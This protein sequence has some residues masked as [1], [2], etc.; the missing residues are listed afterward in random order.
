MRFLAFSAPYL[1]SS[2]QRRARV[3]MAGSVVVPDF[4]MMLMEKSLPSSS[5]HSSCHAR[6]DR[7]LPAKKT[8]GSESFR[9]WFWPLT[10]SMAARG[11]RYEPP[12]PTTTNTSE[13]ARMRSAARRMRCSSSVSSN[14][15]SSSQPR[16]SLP[17][18]RP[19]ASVLCAAKTS[20]SVASRSGRD[21][22]PQT[23]E[24]STFNMDTMLLCSVSPPYVIAKRPKTQVTSEKNCRSSRK[25]C[26]GSV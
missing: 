6:V 2:I 14:V 10:S 24:R 18:P 23:F 25:K 4:E 16:K 5:S 22:S 7:L 13:S 12:M 17:G 1:R 11:P 8:C 20:C 9:L 3:A 21:R 15:G 26:C 19:S